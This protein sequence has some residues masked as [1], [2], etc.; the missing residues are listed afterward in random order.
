MKTIKERID[1]LMELER[2]QTFSKITIGIWIRSIK[3][4][5]GGFSA[6]LRCPCE[7][8]GIS[9]HDD[10]CLEYDNVEEDF[11]EER[12]DPRQEMV[13]WLNVIDYCGCRCRRSR[14]YGKFKNDLILRVPHDRETY[15]KHVDYFINEL[16]KLI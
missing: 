6:V 4:S 8:V 7:L 10:L 12:E 15:Y 2:E 3:H 9:A 1:Q 14:I 13:D 16:K 5:K 11:E